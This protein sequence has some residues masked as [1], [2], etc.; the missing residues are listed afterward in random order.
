MLIN[1]AER[2]PRHKLDNNN[3]HPH[4]NLL[5]C[6]LGPTMQLTAVAC[7]HISPDK[8]GWLSWLSSLPAFG[9]SSDPIQAFTHSTFSVELVLCA[10]SCPQP[11]A[12]VSRAQS[13]PF[14]IRCP[15]QLGS[16]RVLA[17]SIGPDPRQTT[18][19][20]GLQTLTLTH[21]ILLACLLR[22]RGP[23]QLQR[24]PAVPAVGM[25]PA[26]RET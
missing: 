2:W 13:I 22:I 8:Q 19:S 5:N 20:A 7:Q 12:D 25:Q 6:L 4:R 24:P 18:T 3:N 16:T 10:A 17:G 14:K 1:P 9:L 21:S 23:M 26:R 11:S 15:W